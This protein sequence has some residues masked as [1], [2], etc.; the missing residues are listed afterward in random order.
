MLAEF[1]GRFS[2][3]WKTWVGSQGQSGRPTVNCLSFLGITV[4]LHICCAELAVR[5]YALPP[6][7]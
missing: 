7:S 2:L 6:S 4:W 3:D 1:M 5:V